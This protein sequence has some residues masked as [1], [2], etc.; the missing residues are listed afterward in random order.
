M[1]IMKVLIDIASYIGGIF[2]LAFLHQEPLLLTLL[3]A[4]FA[5]IHLTLLRQ[6]ND[7]AFFITGCI[8]GPIVDLIAVPYGVWE[9]SSSAVYGLPLWLPLALGMMVVLIKRIAENFSHRLSL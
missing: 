2:L 8:I 3:V 4:L 1:R 9:Y 6:K 5:V 7:L